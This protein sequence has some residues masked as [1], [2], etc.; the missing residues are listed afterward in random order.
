MFNNLRRANTIESCP[1]CHRIVY[2]EDI[3]K[4]AEAQQEDAGQGNEQDA[5]KD[6]KSAAS[7]APAGADT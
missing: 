7:S 4:D 6:A 5:N 1:Y 3:M 2:W